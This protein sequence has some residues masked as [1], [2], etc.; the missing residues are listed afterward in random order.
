MDCADS[1][2]DGVASTEC[3]YW[4]GDPAVGEGIWYSPGIGHSGLL[5]CMCQVFQVR[6]GLMT[7]SDLRDFSF[8]LQLRVEA[9]PKD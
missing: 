1:F 6:N 4:A 5:V 2:L 7:F 9:V 3:Y 8:R